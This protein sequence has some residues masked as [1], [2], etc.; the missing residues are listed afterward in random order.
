MPCKNCNCGRARKEAE[1]RAQEAKAAEEAK[2]QFVPKSSLTCEE[3]YQEWLES[4]ESLGI[5]LVEE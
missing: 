3:E 5:R 1:R 4:A 2:V